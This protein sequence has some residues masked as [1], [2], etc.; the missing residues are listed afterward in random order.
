MHEDPETLYEFLDVEPSAS[1]EEI[2]EAYR[3]MAARCHPDTPSGN[4]E[5]MLRLNKA[6]EV[7]ADPT[8]RARYD[9]LGHRRYISTT[10]LEGWWH[11]AESGATTSG[12]SASG[13]G[14]DRDTTSRGESASTASQSGTG[15]AGRAGPASDGGTT[16]GATASDETNAE[17]QAGGSSRSAGRRADRGAT[18][19]SPSGDRGGSG[20]YARFRE[21]TMV[22]M[23]AGFG[24]WLVITLERFGWAAARTGGDVGRRLADLNLLEVLDRI[25]RIGPDLPFAVPRVLVALALVVGV[26]AIVDLSALSPAASALVI[27]ACGALSLGKELTLAVARIVTDG[28]GTASDPADPVWVLNVGLLG[29][30]G[31]TL[32]AAGSALGTPEGMFDLYVGLLYL[33]LVYVLLILVGGSILALL[34]STA[35][36]WAWENVAM[37]SWS[38]ACL[39]AGYRVLFSS[40]FATFE[41]L[42]VSGE[43]LWIG[44]TTVGPLQIGRILNVTL[45]AVMT[46]TLLLSFLVTIL[47]FSTIVRRGF[48]NHEYPTR[49][50]LWEAGLV[51]PIL[52][53]VWTAMH[54]DRVLF[55]V[56]VGDVGTA[57]LVFV[58]FVWPPLLLSIYGAWVRTRY[59]PGAGVLR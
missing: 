45:G 24:I 34:V 46:A 12:K 37:A 39:W 29:L 48:F 14:S 19:A 40:S 32:F 52:A 33:P 59:V 6:K 44:F 35:T 43:D 16:D 5:A 55:G 30:V 26:S 9:R 3:C 41:R 17:A 38:L 42:G 2:L 51:G 1:R 18:G 8:E 49:P 28:P 10:K 13:A 11:R 23:A 21:E 57:L 4:T 36:G 50:L 31:L 7:L 15:T 22:S 58:L 54:A 20:F 53:L 47:G 25:D 27:V 56:Q